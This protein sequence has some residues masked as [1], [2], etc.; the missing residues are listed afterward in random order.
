MLVT[1]TIYTTPEQLERLKL[2]AARRKVSVT[3]LVRDGI[4]LVLANPPDW[5][6]RG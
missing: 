6:S 2:L 4:D 3:S 5:G 1:C